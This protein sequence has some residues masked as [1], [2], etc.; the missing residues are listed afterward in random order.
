MCISKRHQINE[1]KYDKL[2]ISL[3]IHDALLQKSIIRI[4]VLV[5]ELLKRKYVVLIYS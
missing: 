2:I 4:I 5:Y 1:D 3:E